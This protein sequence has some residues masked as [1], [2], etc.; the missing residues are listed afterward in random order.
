MWPCPH[1]QVQVLPLIRD[2]FLDDR[3]FVDCLFV[4][5]CYGKPM[6]LFT[7]SP[8]IHQPVTAFHFCKPSPY[9]F[10]SS[11][12][13]SWGNYEISSHKSR[14]MLFQESVTFEDV[15]VNFSHEEWQ[16]L[17]HAQRHLYKDVMLENYGNMVSLGKNVPCTWLSTFSLPFSFHCFVD[18]YEVS[19]WKSEPLFFI[20]SIFLPN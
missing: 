1:S 12:S 8:D 5:F 10:F 9:K 11:A 4:I 20:I 16:C 18:E 17:T 14:N 13:V 15:A 7:S 19:Y 6:L 3:P 2:A